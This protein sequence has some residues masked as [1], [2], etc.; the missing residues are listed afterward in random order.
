MLCV[1]QN[2]FPMSREA[3][4]VLLA[5]LLNEAVKVE[6]LVEQVQMRVDSSSRS[7]R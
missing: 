1:L 4:V 3:V 6:Q 2:I 7:S 5:V